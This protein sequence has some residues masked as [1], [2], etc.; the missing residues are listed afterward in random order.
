MKAIVTKFHG[1]GNTR[2]SRVSASDSDGNRVYI[3]LDPTWSHDKSHQ[4]AAIALCQKMGWL[5]TLYQGF[6][7]SGQ[8]VFVWGP[9][10]GTELTIHRH[11][12][13]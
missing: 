4:M 6:L 11:I 10:H 3:S 8:E 5:G 9:P 13:S 2:G 12:L 7:K 1:P